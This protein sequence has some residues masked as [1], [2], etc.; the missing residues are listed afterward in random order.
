MIT[1]KCKMTTIEGGHKLT[2]IKRYKTTTKRSTMAS[3]TEQTREMQK[4]ESQ[5][6]RR[7]TTTKAQLHERQRTKKCKMT[8]I[9][10]QLATETQR[11][12]TTAM[13][14]RII[15]KGCKMTTTGRNTTTETH[16]SNKK[17]PFCL[18]GLIICPC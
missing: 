5:L 8:T 7:R 18:S 9:G 17:E 6:Q 1:K 12:K 2:T 11:P 16:S 15:R 14:W 13:R 10:C 4:D 3:R